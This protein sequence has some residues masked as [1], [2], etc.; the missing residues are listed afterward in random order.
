MRRSFPSG[1]SFTI[2]VRSIG[3]V[4]VCIRVL[5]ISPFRS[6][7]PQAFMSI[8]TSSYIFFLAII[9]ENIRHVTKKNWGLFYHSHI[10]WLWSYWRHSKKV[11][12]SRH[13]SKSVQLLFM[14]IYSS[15]GFFS[16]VSHLTKKLVFNLLSSKNLSE[17]CRGI[18][19]FLYIIFTALIKEFLGFLKVPMSRSCSFYAICWML[20]VFLVHHYKCVLLKQE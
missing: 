1:V 7:Y 12:E 13:C 17:P 18:Q 10:L 4:K 19:T 20:N 14:Q 5:H 6:S 15:R 16:P 2:Q 8:A 3:N 11:R 9:K